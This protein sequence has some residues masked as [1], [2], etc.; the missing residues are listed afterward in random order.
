MM[1]TNDAA[2]EA[3]YVSHCVASNASA[4]YAGAQ[5]LWALSEAEAERAGRA[6]C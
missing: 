5:P 6:L 1:S 3:R 2:V 4:T